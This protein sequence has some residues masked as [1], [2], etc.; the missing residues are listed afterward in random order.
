MSSLFLWLGTNNCRQFLIAYI[1]FPVR[2]SI[3]C[4][5]VNGR[6]LELG[7]YLVSKDKD[8]WI[9]SKESVDI[10]ERS[11]GCLWIKEIGSGNK[12]RA[13]YGP[14]DPEFVTQVFDSRRRDLSHHVIHYPVSGHGK[15][16]SLGSECQGIYFRWVQPWYAENA[17]GETGKKDKEKTNSNDTQLE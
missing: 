17:H 10:F 7:G 12:G 11:V 6:S 3:V 5:F 13:N 15:T 8:T 1:L 4:F 2:N 9:V 16:R 14:D